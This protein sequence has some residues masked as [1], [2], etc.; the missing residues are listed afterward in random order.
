M[1]KALFLLLLIML[2]ACNSGTPEP[3][4][5]AIVKP[6]ATVYI[7]P[8]PNAEERSGTAAASSPV[9]PPPTASPIPSPTAYIGVF[10]GEAQSSDGLAL[11]IGLDNDGNPNPLEACDEAISEHFIKTWEDNLTIA[12]N[13]GCPIQESYGFFG[14][15]QVFDQGVMYL[16][17]STGEIWIIATK[18]DA[19]KFWYVDH[20]PPGST[21]GLVAPAGKQIPAGDFGN[22]WVGIPGVQEA[23]GYGVTDRQAVAINIQRFQRGTFLK[24]ETSERIYALGITGRL[25]GPF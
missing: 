17:D 16:N 1:R 20:I 19:A 9:P 14:Q 2:S 21:D 11:G 24:D 5:V 15:V 13:M 12:D 10:L 23:L 6:L 8:T 22:V 25:F 18:P 4:A 3:S 7:S